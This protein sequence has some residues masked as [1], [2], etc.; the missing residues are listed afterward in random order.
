MTRAG[1]GAEE[2]RK[3][4]ESCTAGSPGEQ[5][6]CEADRVDDRSRQPA[7]GHPFRLVIDEGEV[8]AC[9]VCD[10]HRVARELEKTAHSDA[11]VRLST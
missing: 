8:E 5:P 2:L 4:P 7:A 6:A 3:R 10:E 1:R 11:R 9:V